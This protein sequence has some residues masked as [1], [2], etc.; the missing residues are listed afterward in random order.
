MNL[1]K[2]VL[3]LAAV[4]LISIGIGLTV[5]NFTG[6]FESAIHENNTV[7]EEKN[8]S[9]EGIDQLQIEGTSAEIH[10]IPEERADVKAHLYGKISTKE[11]PALSMVPSGN[12]LAIKL[13]DTHKVNIGFFSSNLTLD[14]YVPKDY[15]GDLKVHSLS[16]DV[17]LTDSLTLNSATFNLLSGNATINNLNVKDF[18]F[19]SSSGDFLGENLV[20]ES[21]RVDMLSGNMQ[22]RNFQGDLEGDSSSG[23]VSVHYAIFKNQINMKMLSGNLDIDLPDD[24]AF[25]LDANALSG[26]I[27]C[28]FPIT[29][30]EKTERNE[31]KGTV[32]DGTHSIIV[33]SSSG[34]IT[35]E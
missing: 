24:A 14:I 1:K 15:Q 27:T 25:Y 4:A 2:L 18:D 3:Y 32:K 28:S 31:L 35:I 34:D 19:K 21:S 29:V 13:G 26:E 10:I 33:K 17:A 9:L 5:I 11:L 20:T 30:N 12:R 22:L 6:G 23:D 8:S 16:G 7:D